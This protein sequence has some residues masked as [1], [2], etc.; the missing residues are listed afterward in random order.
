MASSTKIKV[1]KLRLEGSRN[2]SNKVTTTPSSS[3]N[4]ERNLR[5]LI[6]ITNSIKNNQ[7]TESQRSTHNL[8]EINRNFEKSVSELKKV[9]GNFVTISNNSNSQ[10]AESDQ[11]N[12][13]NKQTASEASS[14]SISRRASSGASSFVSKSHSSSSSSGHKFHYGSSSWFPHRGITDVTRETISGIP[15]KMGGFVPSLGL[16][17]AT[18]GALNPVIIQAIWNPLKEVCGFIKDVL[19]LPFKLLKGLWGTIKNGINVIQKIFSGLLNGFQSILHIPGA[20]FRGIR[21]VGSALVHPFKSLGNLFGFS[22]G[23]KRDASAVD[24]ANDSKLYRR[25]DTIIELLGN[26]SKNTKSEEKKE[27]SGGFLSG[28]LGFL[29]SLIQIGGLL[30]LGYGAFK[31]LGMDKIKEGWEAIKNAKQKD[32][33]WGAIKATISTIV[34]WGKIIGSFIYDWYQES[35]LKETVDNFIGK[36]KNTIKEWWDKDAERAKDPNQ[37]SIHRVFNW[38]NDK[39]GGILGEGWKQVWTN[40]QYSLAN[41]WNILTDDKAL[42]KYQELAEKY[43][44]AETHEI[45]EDISDKDKNFLEMFESMEEKGLTHGQIKEKFKEKKEEYKAILA[46]A[47]KNS[48]SWIGEAFAPMFGDEESQKNASKKYL[49]MDFDIHENNSL[50]E[51]SLT[52]RLFYETYGHINKFMTSEEKDDFSLPNIKK[53]INGFLSFSVSSVIKTGINTVKDKWNEFTNYFIKNKK[54][55]SDYTTLKNVVGKDIADNTFITIEDNPL[56]KINTAFSKV[57]GSFI[58]AFKGKEG[59]E[60]FFDRLTNSVTDFFTSNDGQS[61]ISKFQDSL[62]NIFTDQLPSIIKTIIGW[63]ESKLGQDNLLSSAIKK[64]LDALYGKLSGVQTK[65]VVEDIK[66]GKVTEETSK[67]VNKALFDSKGWI[68]RAHEATS[69]WHLKEDAINEANELKENPL[70]RLALNV[71]E[72]TAWIYDKGRNYTP[73]GLQPGKF[74]EF[75]NDAGVP[76]VGY[77]DEDGEFKHYSVFSGAGKRLLNLKAEQDLLESTDNILNNAEVKNNQAKLMNTKDNET[78]EVIEKGN[79]TNEE[80]LKCEQT[81]TEN[82]KETKLNTAEMVSL[83]TS[84]NKTLEQ[85]IIPVNQTTPFNTGGNTPIQSPGRTKIANQTKQGK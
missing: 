57:I 60:S 18:G 52:D 82:S 7:V 43:I 24:N 56:Y 27:K 35:G 1:P 11:P 19:L 62:V 81:N 84:M 49:L 85:C 37:F 73:K 10:V 46:K 68:T 45:S 50:E 65:K 28:L 59:E 32:G 9:S 70:Y 6:V 40:T 36:V 4:I 75:E 34:D 26:K 78:K 5:E 63:V 12:Y 61:M 72:A 69:L 77:I 38:L 42:E 17:I 47:W 44:D 33:W 14:R 67:K 58:D 3:T 39:I 74:V 2:I 30:A 48:T 71:G 80:I 76:H 51:Y 22:S 15:G 25:L 53:T 29:P 21:G 13:P 23:Q 8:A 64:S 31:I 20:I 66:Q 16:S 79:A 41:G 54:Q 83:L 55:Y